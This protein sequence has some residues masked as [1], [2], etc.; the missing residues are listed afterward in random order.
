[1]SMYLVAGLGNPG[2]EYEGTRHNVGFDVIDY[3]AEKL[4]FSVSKIKFKGLIGDCNI[5]GEKVIFL[6]PSTFMNLSGESVRDAAE[7]YKIPVQ[8]VIIIYDEVAV[9][10]GRIRIRPSGSDGG[11][12][13]MKS[14]IFQLNSDKFPRIRVG[15]GAPK[16][17][18]VHHVLGKFTEDEKKLMA[19]SIKA[20]S[21]AALS[22]I[23][24]GVQSSMNRYNG[25]KAG[26]NIK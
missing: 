21:D 13:G 22:I 6:K 25:F 24:N 26:D 23:E 1:M 15:I 9:E 19:E 3:L 16:F 18:M 8:N 11:H 14:I 7:F 20:A 4:N 12:N 2:R 10:A 5:K 17:D